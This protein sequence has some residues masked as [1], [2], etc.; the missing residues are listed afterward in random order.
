M[1]MINLMQRLAELDAQNPNIVSEV[2]KELAAKAYNKMADGGDDSKNRT[3]LAGDQSDRLKARM[4]KRWG[5]DASDSAVQ[6]DR[7]QGVA[8]TN[9]PIVS[10]SSCGEQFKIPGRKDGFSSCKDHEGR[11]ALD[12]N[13]SIKECGMMSGGM[14][15]PHTPASINMTADSGAELT[16]M[17]KDIMSLAGL[18]QVGADDLGH[19]HQPAVVTAEPGVSIAKIDDSSMMRSVIDKLN[20]S[21]EETDEGAI[22]GGI[23][24][25][26]GAALAGPLGAVA[27]GA[28]GAS[29]EDE[30]VNEWDN[31]PTDIEDIPSIKKD[32]MLNKGR[33]NQ[34]PAGTP[35]AGEGRNQ[36]NNPIATPEATYESLMSEYKKF[37]SEN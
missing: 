35:G 9:Q 1:Q 7:K 19:E 36:M 10:C 28:M 32:A 24:A 23:G 33:H 20:P 15:Q 26:L 14:S 30:S 3:G 5:K 29:L 37:I 8:E 34:T 18:K 16:N 25:G 21:D 11:K 2:S 12:E 31:E 22:A 4:D 6:K 17:L 27:G 13:L